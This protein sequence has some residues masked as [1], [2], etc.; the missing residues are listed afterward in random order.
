MTQATKQRKRYTAEEKLSIVKAH[1]IGKRTV[2]ELCEEHQIAPSLF[3][4]W[5]QTLFEYGAQV[6]EKKT[7]RNG[8]RDSR[9]VQRLQR[10]LEK[11]Q[12]KLNNKHEVLS[13]LMSEH[14]ALKKV[15]ATDGVLGGT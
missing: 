10:E 14:V 8:Q 7:A 11:T 15:L 3:Y 6:L 5:Q 9:Q 4:Q 13:E 2:S 1:L 12:A